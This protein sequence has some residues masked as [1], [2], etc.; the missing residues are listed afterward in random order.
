M[1][2]KVAGDLYESITGQLFEIGR[3]LRQ[4]GG[5]PFEPTALQRGLQDLIEGRF[6][7]KGVGNTFSITCNGIKTSVL[8][9]RGQYDW[10]NASIGDTLFSIKKHKPVTRQIELVEFDHTVTSEEVLA[11]FA[12]RGLERPTYEDGLVFGVMYPEEQRKHPVVFLHEA[13]QVSGHRSVLVLNESVG[14]RHLSLVWFGGRWFRF[15]VFAAV[16]K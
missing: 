13:V 15:Y 11:E 8:V 7:N 10:T 4:P 2:T 12:R 16:R 14:M 9:K 6:E 1:A 3:Q 5:Y